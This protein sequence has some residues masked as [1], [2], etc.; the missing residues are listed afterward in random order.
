MIFMLFLYKKLFLKKKKYFDVSG[1]KT[2]TFLA[3]GV[4]WVLNFE[5]NCTVYATLTSQN[6][7]FL[8]SILLA[9]E[10]PVICCTN[11]FRSAG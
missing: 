9:L 5:F 3:S 11:K 1:N 8:I 2:F 4:G 10:M 7:E 6:F